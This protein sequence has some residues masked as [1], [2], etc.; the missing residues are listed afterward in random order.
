MPYTLKSGTILTD[1]EIQEIVNI[2]FEPYKVTAFTELAL[3]QTWRKEKA[4]KA[5]AAVRDSQ[6][7]R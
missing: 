3:R 5:A 7:P 6:P 4:A 2:L 1:E